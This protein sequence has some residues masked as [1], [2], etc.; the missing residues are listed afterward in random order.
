M[1]HIPSNNF[2][3]Y[4]KT[5]V[6][7]RR[8]HGRPSR[9]YL[10]SWGRAQWVFRNVNFPPD[11]LATSRR[12]CSK[13]PLCLSYISDACKNTLLNLFLRAISHALNC[14]R[15][16]TYSA[17]ITQCNAPYGIGS[18]TVIFSLKYVIESYVSNIALNYIWRPVRHVNWM[19]PILD[20]WHQRHVDI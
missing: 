19:A 9:R 14:G 15:Y 6:A 18:S 1:L 5:G 7:R 8:P 4:Y 16:M 11:Y 10:L 12:Q 3:F 17:T 13:V 20:V 2:L